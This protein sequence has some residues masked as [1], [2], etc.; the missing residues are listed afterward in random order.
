MRKERIAIQAILALG[1]IVTFTLAFRQWSWPRVEIWLS[2]LIVAGGIA[3]ALIALRLRSKK[4]RPLALAAALTVT[5]LFSIYGA[6]RLDLHLGIAA[7]GALVALSW[8]LL[9]VNPRMAKWVIQASLL[10]AVIQCWVLPAYLW[11]I[12]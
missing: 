3:S 7:N 4:A 9:T 1:V 12:R 2:T 8:G 5:S 6:L 10:N 11:L